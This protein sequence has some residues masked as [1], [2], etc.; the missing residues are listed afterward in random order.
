MDNR[1]QATSKTVPSSEQNPALEVK[2]GDFGSFVKHLVRIIPK[3]D[4]YVGIANG[5][6]IL[7]GALASYHKAVFA[8]LQLKHYDGRKMLDVVEKGGF[9]GRYKGDILVVDDIA[10]TGDTLLMAK[11]IIP[12]AKTLTLFKKTGSK[13]TPDYYLQS[14]EK[15]VKFPWENE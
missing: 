8:F 5:G 3:Y 7:A 9:F 6:V 12:E 1:G 13:I 10:D 14:T 2:W 15:W 11:G 4:T